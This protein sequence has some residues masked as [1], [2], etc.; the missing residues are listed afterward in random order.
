MEYDTPNMNSEHMRVVDDINLF[1]GSPD[2]YD[3]KLMGKKEI[4]IPYNNN[5]LAQNLNDF[6]DLLTPHH[7]NPESLRYELHRVWVLDARLKQGE[8]HIYPRRVLYIDEDSWNAVIAEQYRSNEELWRVSLSYS[9]YFPEMPGTLT[10]LDAYHDLKKKSYYIQ[11]RFKD[12][13]RAFEFLN[14]VPDKKY[15][16]PSGLRRR[17]TQ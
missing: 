16:S 5:A 17:A 6:D 12:K 1:N 14:E 3:W 2:R 9:R 11:S 7:I 8:R 10:V 4:F 13:N 15:F